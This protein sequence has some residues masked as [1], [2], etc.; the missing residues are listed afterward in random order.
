MQQITLSG[1]CSWF[2]VLELSHNKVKGFGITGSV[3]RRLR[4][5]YCYPSASIQTF[6]NLYYG[7]RS[8]VQAL[9]RWFKN[10]YRSELL[11]LVDKKLEWIDPKS[12]LNDLKKIVD[13]IESR[14]V[15]CN[16][17]ELYRV[18]ANHLPFRPSKYFAD[19]KTN[20]DF[21]LEHILT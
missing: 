2:Y 8:Q 20:P 1:D 12:E 5:G 21:F 3:E 13:T 16:Y 15:A 6:C 4:K 19:I 9:E 18:K 17:T 7:K 14:I 11:V 10:E